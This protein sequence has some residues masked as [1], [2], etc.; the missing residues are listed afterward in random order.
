MSFKTMLIVAAAALLAACAPGTPTGTPSATALPPTP[1]PTATGDAPSVTLQF[2]TVLPDQSVTDKELDALL[3]AFQL[4][5]PSIRIVVSSQPT[6][7]ELNRR[8]VAS[9]AAGTLPDLVTGTDTD[10]AQYARTRSLA[11]LDDFIADPANGLSAAELAEAIRTVFEGKR[12]VSASL[13]EALALRP[14]PV[15]AA[16]A[17]RD[18][19]RARPQR[20][21]AAAIGRPICYVSRLEN[22]G[23]AR[24]TPEIAEALHMTEPIGAIV[25]SVTRGGPADKAGLKGG[26]VIVRFDGIRVDNIYDYT[27]ALRSRK[28]GQDVRITVKRG[29]AE[30]DLVATLG[31]RP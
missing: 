3:H 12:F 18:D 21:L 23:Y 19:W 16:D 31:R 13:R 20:D 22:G 4:D 11:P 29:G 9:V 30:K 6:A 26:D 25:R 24:L 15:R 14:D 17:D 28:P 27:F 2:W 7:T 10:I 5:Y 8:V 1:V